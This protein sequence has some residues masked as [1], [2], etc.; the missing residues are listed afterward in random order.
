MPAEDYDFESTDSLPYT[1]VPDPDR[2]G[3]GMTMT[4]VEL[5]RFFGIARYDIDRAIENG[6]P[7]LVKGDQ[8]TP[9]QLPS[10]DFLRWMIEDK[11][12]RDGDADLSPLRRNQIKLIV[13]Q[14]QKLEMKNAESKRELVTIDEV[15]TVMRETNDI[16]RKHLRAVPTAVAKALGELKPEDRR[17]ASLV[18]LVIADCINDALRTISTEGID[19]VEQAA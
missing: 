3:P 16:V 6:A 11:A 2:T 1:P 5:S 8:F 7:V 4:K 14:C 9:W 17:N 13:S 12:K 18:E 10:G 15:V 19:H